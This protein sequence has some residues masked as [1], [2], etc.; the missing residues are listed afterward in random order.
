MQFP[1]PTY[2]PSI[3]I[4]R[5]EIHQNEDFIIQMFHLAGYGKVKAIQF[6]SKTGQ[7]GEPYRAAIVHFHFWF[8]NQ[9]VQHLWDGI[10]NSTTNY[11]QMSHTQGYWYISIYQEPAALK[12]PPIAPVMLSQPQEQT[13][14]QYIKWLEL[15]VQ[16]LSEQLHYTRFQLDEKKKEADAKDVE[17]NHTIMIVIDLRDKLEIQEMRKEVIQEEKEIEKAD[18]FNHLIQKIQTGV[19]SFRVNLDEDEDYDDSDE[20]E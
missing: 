20:E 16:Q 9:D 17:L 14:P 18:H 5:C 1:Q 11:V 19:A 6:F 10:H 12:A 3:Y 2:N 7:R 8:G 13:P 15:Q 4:R